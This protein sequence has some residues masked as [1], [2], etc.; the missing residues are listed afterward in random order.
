MQVS[1]SVR[2]NIYDSSKSRNPAL[3][4]IQAL[5]RYRDLLVQLVRRD[6][7][8]RYKRSFLGVLWTMLNPLGTMVI[9]SIVFSQVF[10][11]KGVYP[12]YIITNLVAWSFFAQTTQFSLNSTLWGSQLFSKIYMPRTSFVVSTAGTGLVNLFFAL[13]PL[14]L[15]FLVTRVPIHISTLL[16]PAA[17]LLLIAFALG[18]SLI[19]STL[20]V[21]FPDVSEFYPVLLTAWMYLTPS[22][23]P[24]NLLA[25]NPFGYWI[26]SLNPLY[27]VLKLF[28]MLLFDGVIPSGG[29]WLI[30]GIVAAGTLLV[31]WYLFTSKSKVF[32]YY[33]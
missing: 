26:M 25:N 15:I 21:F 22:I 27:R 12:A 31:G 14:F 11:M 4:E 29:E 7:I 28:R 19:L 9:L 32:G 33:V 24:E 1:R 10:N 2:K 30:G 18:V 5:I 6:I 3:E 8:A 13:V 16:L 17:I 23:Y 20:T